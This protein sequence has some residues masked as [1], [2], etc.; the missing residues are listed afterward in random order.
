MPMPAPAQPIGG[1][2]MAMPGVHTH[3]VDLA[4]LP[5]ELVPAVTTL[6]ELA[7]AGHALPK[8]RDLLHVPLFFHQMSGLRGIPV[9]QSA[10][11]NPGQT[12]EATFTIPGIYDYFCGVHGPA[13]S[14]RVTV[15]AGGPNLIDVQAT[16]ANT[17]VQADVVVGVGGKVRWTNTG[18]SQHS[19]IESGGVN[20]PSLCFNGRSFIGNAPTIVA[21]SG[22]RIRWYVFNLDLGMDWHNFHPHAQRWVFAGETIDVRSIG[23][24]ESFVVETVTPPVLLLPEKI[25]KC[26][27]PKHRPKRAKPYALRGDFLVHC[28]VEM[29]MMEGLAALVRAHQKVWLTDAQRT[30]LEQ[31]A[32]LPLDPGGNECPAVTPNRCAT[33]QTGRWEVLP[34]LP[35]VTFM[36]AVLLPNTSRL[37]FWGYGPRADQARLWDQATAAYTVPVNQPATLHPDQNIWSGAHAHLADAAGKILVH[38][39]MRTFVGPPI[40]A[41]TE[42]RSF[43]FDPATRTWAATGDMHI[44]RFYPTTISLADGRALTMYGADNFTDP[45][46]PA[47][48]LETFTPAAGGGTWSPPKPVSFANDDYYYYPWAFL[49]P[50]GDVFIAGPQRPARRFDPAA[51]PIVDNPALQY[52]QVYPQRG[53][54]MEG[55][56]VLLPL[57]PPG[58]QPR[59]LICGG[60][61][62][63][64][65]NWNA[66]EGGAMKTTEWIDLSAAGAA[67]QSLPDMNI[68]RGK[69]NSVLLPDGRVAV[70]GGWA[71]PPDGG[72][73]EIFDPED[74]T[75]GWELGPSMKYN[76]GYHSSA[77]LM[78]DGSIVVGGDPNGDTTPNERYLP[79]YFF[80]PRPQITG[81]PAA[82]GYGQS[83]S[84]Q[85]PSPNGISQVVLMRP[86]AVTHGFNMSQRSVGC[87]ITG[88]GAGTVNVTAP[89][90]GNVSPPGHHLLFLIDHDRTPSEGTWIHLS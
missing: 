55:T 85:T 68:E 43:A 26:Q 59:V 72:P 46:V 30:E 25:Q 71:N 5:A 49:L 22:Q 21:H 13:M 78:P 24:A 64:R 87:A 20:R 16:A 19:V 70:L 77:I 86:G 54:N 56:A 81:A 63:T 18:G 47:A 84:V 79:S 83:F 28:H 32:G 45:T 66:G 58:Y 7:H 34:G 76:R 36:H 89:P 29:H 15:Q 9:F 50:L 65:L 41:D 75:A 38:G 48:S 80:K 74:P 33:T 6:E 4:E 23:P 53:V 82:I 44:G 69:L 2:P 90:D 17:F 27:D 67:W 3:G 14:G 11:F 60:T 31:T 35:G 62:N 10:P 42:R 57:E 88:A 12:Y 1:M 37:L 52:P 61:G 40:T 39:G 73:I 8:P 51:S